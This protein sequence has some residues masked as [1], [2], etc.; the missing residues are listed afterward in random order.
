[1]RVCGS[2]DD[3]RGAASEDDEC[4]GLEERH[5]DEEGGWG[6]RA[7]HTAMELHLNTIS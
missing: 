7:A 3:E 4:G 6:E 2:E 1:M 5:C